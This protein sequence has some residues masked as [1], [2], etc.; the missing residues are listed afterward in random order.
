M[1]EEN[2]YSFRKGIPKFKTVF[3]TFL[4]VLILSVTIYGVSLI[5]PWLSDIFVASSRTPWGII[6]SLFTHLELQHLTSNLTALFVYFVIFVTS[7]ILLSMEE[8]E[9]RVRFFLLTIFIMAIMSNLVWIILRPDTNTTGASGLV[10]ASEGVVTG[11]ALLNSL[12]L[13]DIGKYDSKRQKLLLAIY[14]YNLAIFLFLFL[15]IV[16]APSLF[17]N[18]APGVNAF[19]HGIAFYISFLAVMLFFQIF[20]LVRRREHTR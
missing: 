5:N 6:T 9:R 11:F 3:L 14:I 8:I 2:S 4:V 18:V 19:V 17:L 20:P 13:I 16:L 1:K 10:F 12:R 7:N 15:Q